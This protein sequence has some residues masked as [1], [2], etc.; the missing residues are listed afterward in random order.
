MKKKTTQKYFSISRFLTLKEEKRKKLLQDAEKER[1]ES[2]KRQKEEDK[3]RLEEEY[4][5]IERQAQELL[6]K[7]YEEKLAK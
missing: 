4:E 7:D 2:E 5:K 1:L 3:R 6:A